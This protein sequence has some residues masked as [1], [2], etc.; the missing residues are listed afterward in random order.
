MCK[1][2]YKS[3]PLPFQGQKRR[4]ISD[5]RDILTRFDN[6]DTVIDLFGGSGLLANTV[7]RAR[8][9]LNVILMIMTTIVKGF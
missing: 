5:L 7:K 9:E 2:V 6:I 8:P 3:A 4:S 1:K